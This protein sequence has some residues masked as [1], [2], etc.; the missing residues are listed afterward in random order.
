VVRLWW[1]HSHGRKRVRE[2]SDVM[3][4]IPYTRTSF[5][6]LN[7][8]PKPYHH[9]GHFNILILGRHKYSNNNKGKNQNP[10]T[11]TFFF[12]KWYFI[13]FI[14]NFLKSFL[15]LLTCVYIVWAPSPPPTSRQ[16]LF[17]PLVLWFRWRKKHVR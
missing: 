8:L 14:F 7:R 9:L 16:N 10:W 12:K 5:L 1:G 6:Q 3:A 17:C 2:L 15:H 13:L 11:S 4:L